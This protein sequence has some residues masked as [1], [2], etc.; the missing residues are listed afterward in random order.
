MGVQVISMSSVVRASGDAFSTAIGD[1]LVIFDQTGGSYYGAG[2]VG[3]RIWALIETETNVS[4]LCDTLEREFD[5]R[6][7][8]CE[9]EVLKFLG[10]LKERNLISLG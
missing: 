2:K 1:E 9:A 8:T 5:V 4:D 3:S 10:D 6:R 7:D